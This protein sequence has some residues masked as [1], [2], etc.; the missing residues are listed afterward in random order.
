MRCSAPSRPSGRQWAGSAAASG[1]PT[2]DETATPDKVGTLQPLHPGI[3]LLVPSLG[4]HYVLG[5]IQAKWASLGW[6]R[7]RLGYPRS[8]EF[9]IPG[10][11]RSNFQHGYITRN[12]KTGA[13]AVVYTA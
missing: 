9:G 5:A 13:I 7:G 10:G 2:T 3:D 6:E 12:L 11:R 1:Y 4:A 8:D